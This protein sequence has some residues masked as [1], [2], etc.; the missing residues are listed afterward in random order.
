MALCMFMII[1]DM[2]LLSIHVVRFAIFLQV[3]D[4]TGHDCIGNS[5]CEICN[6]SAGN[7]IS[8]K[9]FSRMSF[10]IFLS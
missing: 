1:Q 5:C 6:I 8:S 3:H 4:C 7:K 10:V 9:I 2:I